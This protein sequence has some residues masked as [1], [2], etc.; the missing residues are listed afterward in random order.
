MVIF[1]PKGV[2]ADEDPTR[3]Q[4]FYNGIYNYLLS[5]GLKELP[6]L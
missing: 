6:E 4:E 1:V 3:K 5:C 2:D